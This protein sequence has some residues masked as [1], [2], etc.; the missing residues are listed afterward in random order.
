MLYWNVINDYKTEKVEE[1]VKSLNMKDLVKRLNPD[2]HLQ[3]SVYFS[4]NISIFS[5]RCENILIFS[6]KYTLIWRCVSGFNRF[7][8]SFIFKLFTVSS[9][10][11]V[12]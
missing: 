3:I 1:T 7:T 10:F 12:L 2:T 11:S 4:E 5:Q 9:T 6:E 8:K